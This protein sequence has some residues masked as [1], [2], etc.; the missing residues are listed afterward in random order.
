MLPRDES[1]EHIGLSGNAP[2]E[3]KDFSRIS[4]GLL[5]LVG[6][7][8]LRESAVLLCRLFADRTRMIRIFSAS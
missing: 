3:E 7:V 5:I 4:L 8:S 6:K 2:E 1:N